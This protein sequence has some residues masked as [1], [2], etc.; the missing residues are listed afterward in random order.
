MEQS[1]RWYDK[2]PI[3]SKAMKILE[4]TNDQFQV[5]IAINLIK[6]IIEH[7]IE[8]DAF[9]S[10]DDLLSAVEEGRCE[11]GN[12]RWYDLDKTLR[13]AIQML[14]NCSEEMQSKIAKDVASL[15]KE[16]IRDTYE[17]EIVEQ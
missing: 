1:R 11:K 7:N 9:R 14:E 4:S 2:D 6:I 17:A 13:T 10:I 5:K 8:T 12:E 16:K 3:L 15:I